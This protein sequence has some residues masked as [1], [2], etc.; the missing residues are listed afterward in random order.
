MFYD[1]AGQSFQSLVITQ[2]HF[3]R[4]HRF[5]ALGNIFVGGSFIGTLLIVGIYLFDL[6]TIKCYIS[7]ARDILN[8]SRDAICHSLLHGVAIHNLTKDL[9]SLINGRTCKAYKGCVGEGG[10]QQFSIRLRDERS[11]LFSLLA[12]LDLVFHLELAVQA[13]LRAVRFVREAHDV[14]SLV[15]QSCILTELLDGTD[16]EAS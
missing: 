8:V 10:A 15:E 16:E 5:L 9:N 4:T 6:I 13:H 12:F 11:Q 7:D 1:V 2:N 14:A 3:H